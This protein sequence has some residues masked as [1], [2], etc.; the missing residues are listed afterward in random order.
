MRE[1]TLREATIELL[2]EL[3]EPVGPFVFAGHGGRIARL[4]HRIQQESG[5]GDIT[6]VFRAEARVRE[7]RRAWADGAP[8]PA[9]I[10]VLLDLFIAPPPEAGRDPTA[11]R[12]EL[13][14]LLYLCGQRDRAALAAGLN[15]RADMLAPLAAELGEWFAEDAA[16]RETSD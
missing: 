5:D 14:E 7:I 1:L 6:G 9:T 13:T 8:L 16:T 4:R 15:A 2:A 11:W 3:C 10:G 12:D